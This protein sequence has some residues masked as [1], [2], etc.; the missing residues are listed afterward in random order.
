MRRREKGGR[1]GEVRG[2]EKERGGK[3]EEGEEEEGRG[4]R[5]STKGVENQTGVSCRCYYMYLGY[6]KTLIPKHTAQH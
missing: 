4:G 3:G 6:N 1:R 2:E 5:R